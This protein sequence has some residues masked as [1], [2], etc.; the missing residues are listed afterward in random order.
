MEEVVV[1]YFD[2]MSQ[3]LTER[4]EEKHVRTAGLWGEI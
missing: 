3:H 4:T 2:V 1:A